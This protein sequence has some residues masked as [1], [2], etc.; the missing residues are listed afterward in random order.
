MYNP[1][2]LPPLLRLDEL[3]SEISENSEKLISENLALASTIYIMLFFS[4][5]L[6]IF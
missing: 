2:N 1:G 6:F 3:I 5:T 4:I